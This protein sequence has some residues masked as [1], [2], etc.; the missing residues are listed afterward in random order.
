MIAVCDG[1]KCGLCRGRGCA[2]PF[3]TLY[4]QDSLRLGDHSAIEN[5]L[6]GGSGPT[7]HSLPFWRY[8]GSWRGQELRL[9][10]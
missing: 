5:Q 6:V 10:L 2:E 7:H 4:Q 9:R 8:A 3:P 1:L